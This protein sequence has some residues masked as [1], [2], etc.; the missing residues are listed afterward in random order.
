MIMM[1]KIA[2]LIALLMIVMV[3]GC[4]QITVEQPPV[5]DEGVSQ[6]HID[7]EC[8]DERIPY[9]DEFI[10]YSEGCSCDEL[11]NWECPPDPC[12]PEIMPEQ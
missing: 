12:P 11:G 7:I 3:S 10:M 5:E 1:K 8:T 9:C 6:Q 2:V 4:I